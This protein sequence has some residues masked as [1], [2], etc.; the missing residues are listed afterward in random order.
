M[1]KLSRSSSLEEWA[2]KHTY[3]EGLGLH[4]TDSKHKI[5]ENEAWE[6]ERLRRAVTEEALISRLAKKNGNSDFAEGVASA[7]VGGLTGALAYNG[8]KG[9]GLPKGLAGALGLGAGAATLLT[10]YLARRQRIGKESG[11]ESGDTVMVTENNDE[12]AWTMHTVGRKGIKTDPWVREYLGDI[13][14]KKLRGYD[15]SNI[16]ELDAETV[17][18]SKEKT[19]ARK[20]FIGGILKGLA[21]ESRLNGRFK[22]KGVKERIEAAHNALPGKAAREKLLNIVRKSAKD[23]MKT[24]SWVEDAVTTAA[25]MAGGVV[26]KSNPNATAEVLNTVGDAATAAA[27]KFVRNVLLYGVLP[28]ASVP[29]ALGGVVAANKVRSM[30]AARRRLAA[31]KGIG[32]GI[33]GAAGL[34]AGVAL[35]EAVADKLT[36]RS[37][38]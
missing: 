32:K 3:R 4:K 35:G 21:E 15:L 26:F 31:A 1:N 14:R 6:A 29:L 33:A 30:V 36:G 25:G 22:T 20:S 5:K 16:K 10:A 2:N 11:I 17:L 28:A 24:A 18:K 38:G 7:G 23:K 12:D 34:G 27:D 8:L 19:A 9:S 13:G 37:S